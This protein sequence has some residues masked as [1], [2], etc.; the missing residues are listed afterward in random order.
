LYVIDFGTASVMQQE[1]AS[2]LATDDALVGII[3]RI[4]SLTPDTANGYPTLLGN[5]QIDSISDLLG[6]NDEK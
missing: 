5:F 1:S 6:E 4:E 2:Q 3:E